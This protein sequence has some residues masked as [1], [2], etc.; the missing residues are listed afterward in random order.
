MLFC[1]TPSLVDRRP[2]QPVHSHV[3]DRLQKWGYRVWDGT[4]EQV[5]GSYPTQL[6]QIRIVQYDSCRGLEAW[7]SVNLRFDELYDYKRRQYT[8][9]AQ[10]TFEFRDEARE[11]QLF[12]A[13]WLMIPLTR[14]I[15]TLVIQI[16]SADHPIAQMLKAAAQACPSVVEWRTLTPPE[17]LPTT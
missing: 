2:G 9:P 4:A 3:A 12:A 6:D 1:V 17:P 7:T 14:A 5:R 10:T 11:A 13:S 16:Q 15:D 8:P